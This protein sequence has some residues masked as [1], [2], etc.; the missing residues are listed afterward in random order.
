M[1]SHQINTKL[2]Q[3]NDKMMVLLSDVVS[4]IK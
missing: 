2:N 1:A 4:M 3:V